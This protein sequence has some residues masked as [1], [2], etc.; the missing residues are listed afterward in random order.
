MQTVDAAAL[1]ELLRLVVLGGLLFVRV[2]ALLLA[3]PVFSSI[4]IPPLFKVSFALLLTVALVPGLPPQPPLE[5]HPWVVVLVVLKESL[6]GLF[7]GMVSSA[8]VYAARFAGGLLD[9]D[10]GFQTA[11]IFDPGL[12]GFPTLIGEFFAMATLMLF[13]W[14]GGH[15]AVLL[16]LQ[17]SVRLVPLTALRFPAVASEE[18]IRWVGALTALALSIAAPV[19]AALFVTLW[20]LALLARTAPQINIFMLSF[21]V[22]LLVGLAMLMVSTPLVVTLLRNALVRLQ[23][24][25]LTLVRALQ[26]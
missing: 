20:A 11:L 10:I 21:S 16:A 2:T 22:K 6:I 1:N 7:L 18:L 17:E 26:P 5:L 9:M 3:A 4:G 12:G 15:Q 14:L 19:L 25:V 23:A 24:D 8:V 13:F